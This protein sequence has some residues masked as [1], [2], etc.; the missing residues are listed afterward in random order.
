MFHDV[1]DGGEWDNSGFAGPAPATYKLS[2]A[3]FAEH[4]GAIHAALPELTTP[5]A[6]RWDRTP[7]VF[8]TFDDGGVTAYDPTAA[9]LESYGWRGHFLVTTARIGTRG[10]LT[11]GQVRELHQRGHSIGSHSATH[12]PRMSACDEGRLRTEW[13]DSVRVLEDIVG[14]PVTVASVPGGYYSRAVG[15]TAAEAGIRILFHSEPTSRVRVTGRCLLVGR[16]AIRRDTP[17]E[18][19]AGFA[20]GRLGPCLRRAAAWNLKKI[21]RAVGADHYLKVRKAYYKARSS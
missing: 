20:A 2:R 13:S 6:D 21:L 19:T 10:F 3:D 12:P 18:M 8:L 17:P 9:L 5:L 11:R 14:A 1:V 15:R 4:L 16:Y 7:A